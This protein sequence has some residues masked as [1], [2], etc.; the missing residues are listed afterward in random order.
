MGCELVILIISNCLCL[1]Y[2]E[3]V[4]LLSSRAEWIRQQ[5]AELEAKLPKNQA[6]CLDPQP[7][8]NSTCMF[9]PHTHVHNPCQL[10]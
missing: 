6:P 1:H 2:P 3:D 8:E 9:A 5:A 7:L 4:M 10:L